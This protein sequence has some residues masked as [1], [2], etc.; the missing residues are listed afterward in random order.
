[1]QAKRK[2]ER[3]VAT[4]W[5]EEEETDVVGNSKGFD[6]GSTVCAQS[7]AYAFAVHCCRKPRNVLSGQTTAND[8]D[9]SVEGKTETLYCGSVVCF[10]SLCRIAFVRNET[11]RRVKPRTLQF[12]VLC[13]RSAG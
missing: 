4:R 12:C 11:R 2:V 8:R 13:D 3:R 1:M 9:E 10:G 7:G 6:V 5:N